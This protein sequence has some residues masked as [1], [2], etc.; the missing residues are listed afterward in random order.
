MIFVAIT[1]VAMSIVLEPA[2]RQQKTV[3]QI[4]SHGGAVGFDDCQ[5]FCIADENSLRRNLLCSACCARIP[6]NKYSKL[7][8][9]LKQLPRLNKIIVYGDSETRNAEIESTF[10]DAKIVDMNQALLDLL[11]N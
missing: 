5:Y 7:E 6:R 4:Q 8:N 11:R 10:P 2:R 3:R 1:F 9:Y